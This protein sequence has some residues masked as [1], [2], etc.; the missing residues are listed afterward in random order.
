MIRNERPRQ[1]IEASEL[2]K[3]LYRLRV[4][5]KGLE[6][7]D[8][9][10]KNNRNFILN[11]GTYLHLLQKALIMMHMYN[12]FTFVHYIIK[13]NSNKSYQQLMYI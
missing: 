11:R 8:G 13:D 6:A 1:S 10:I 5:K 7:W 12:I 2:G 3:S 4:Y 9:V